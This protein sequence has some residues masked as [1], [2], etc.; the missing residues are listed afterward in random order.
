MRTL[1]P[2]LFIIFFGTS[3]SYAQQDV[4]CKDLS[5]LV[6]MESHAQEPLLHFRGNELTDNYDLKYHR[7]EWEVN[8]SHK[9]IAGTV[10]SYF[11]P[12]KAGFQEINF[13]FSNALTINEILYHGST[14]DYVQQANNRL[15]IT[16][17]QMIPVG[18]L[19]SI[20]VIYEG[21]PPASGFG[22]FSTTTHNGSPILWT[23][24]EPYGAMEWWPCKQDLNDK[25]DSIDVYVRTPKE[26]RAASNGI[27]VHE[28]PDGDKVIYHWKHRH[29]IAAYLVAIAVTNYAVY[30]DFVPV[31]DGDSILM[32]NYVFPENLASAQ[33]GTANNVA[34]LQLFNDLFGLYPFADEKFGH[35]QFSWGGGMEHQT[36]S[37]VVNFSHFLLSHELAHQWFGDYVTCGSWEDIWLNEGFATYLE[38]MTYEHGLGPNNWKNWLQGRIA[39]VTSQPGGSV[40]VPDTTSIGRIFNGRL[41]YSKGALV[42]HMLRWKVGDD[43]FFQA[44]G[45]YLNDPAIAYGYAKTADLKAHLEAQSGQ[46]LTEFFDDWFYGEGFPTYH[47][48]WKN[49]ET[50]A[51]LQVDQTTSHPSVD[52]FEMPIPVLLKG[53]GQEFM[54]RLDHTFS[55]QEFNV[56]VPFVVEEVVFDPYPWLISSN[57]TIDFIATDTKEAK[58]LEQSIR[59]APNPASEV[60]E[61]S[62]ENVENRVKKVVLRNVEGKILQTIQPH[63]GA[64]E[65]NV[66]KFVPGTYLLTFYGEGVQVSKKFVKQ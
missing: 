43:N 39:S 3:Q 2:L 5:L 49:T 8:P 34:V 13:D 19:D 29:P 14:V 24:S 65:L 23:L 4:A 46:D 33:I 37:F 61:V 10:T 60:I 53:E 11:T 15:Q 41:S 66:S 50:G 32:L 18:Q 17:P 42:L 26:Y 9:F 38:G 55:G 22:S 25:I 40:F 27:L 28:I 12:T 58:R 36:M 6:E 54:A 20:A 51:N 35:A 45:N 62:F 1:L 7:L 21:T 44:I 16:L 59:L 31:P 57:N 48:A 64:F 30:S 63:S 56:E 52:F 47:I